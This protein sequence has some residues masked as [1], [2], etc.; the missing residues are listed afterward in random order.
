VRDASQQQ[1]GNDAED[2]PD[3]G[4]IASIHGQLLLIAIDGP[5]WN[6]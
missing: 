4:G 2:C 1:R 6:R 3:N 5:D